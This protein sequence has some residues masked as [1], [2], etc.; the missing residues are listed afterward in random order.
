MID[1]GLKPTVTNV[2]HYRGGAGQW[3]WVFHRI[4]GLGVLLFLMLHIFDTSTVY[5]AP[6]AYN[7]FVRL[8][9]NPLFGLSEIALAA[10]LIFHAVNGLK[11]VILDFWP[12]LWKWHDQAQVAAWALFA[13]L[14]VPTGSIM[15]MRIINHYTTVALR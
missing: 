5:F 12:R 15:L 13:I 3:A 9:K 4:S 2:R 8:Y 14:F 11:L 6:G 1:K 10:A 7:F